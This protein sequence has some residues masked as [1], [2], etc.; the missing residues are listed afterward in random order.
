[1]NKS[2]ILFLVSILVS[3]YW[4]LGL[5]INVYN[6]PIVGAIAELLWLPML[7][8]IFIIPVLSL[9]YVFKEKFTIK[10]LYCYSIVVTVVTVIILVIIQ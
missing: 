5:V 6:Y 8:M 2:K 1:M 9:Y 7:A 10:S 3:I 4:L